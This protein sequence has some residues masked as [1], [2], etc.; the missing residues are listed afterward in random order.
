[1]SHTSVSS[2]PSWAGRCQRAPR[3]SAGKTWPWGTCPCRAKEA[4]GG[5]ADPGP[6]RGSSHPQ[7]RAA[8]KGTG[9]FFF[10]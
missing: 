4:A 8:E 10:F 7:H 3:K 5:A 9:L 2:D 6:S 1:M